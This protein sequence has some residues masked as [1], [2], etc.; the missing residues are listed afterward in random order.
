MTYITTESESLDVRS[1]AL[2]FAHKIRCYFHGHADESGLIQ[3]TAI[4]FNAAQQFE[5][6]RRFEVFRAL[7]IDLFRL[8]EESSRQKEKVVSYFKFTKSRHRIDA[9]RKEL[10]DFRIALV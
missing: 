2:D 1:M 9:F 5:V 8:K 10:D 7:L 3:R 6:V 4:Y